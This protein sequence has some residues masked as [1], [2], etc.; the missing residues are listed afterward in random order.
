MLQ[1]KNTAYEGDAARPSAIP[2]CLLE[3]QWAHTSLVG[4]FG[5]HR[6]TEHDRNTLHTSQPAAVR[7]RHAIGRS[8]TPEMQ[9]VPQN[10]PSMHR[11]LSDL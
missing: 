3:G 11:C 4:V 10:E 7:N 6:F 2:A 8:A 1:R 9:S 5:V